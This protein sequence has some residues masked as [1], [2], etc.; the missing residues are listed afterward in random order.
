MTNVERRLIDLAYKYK[1]THLSSCLSTLPILQDIY[2]AK[3]PE[4]TVVL[5]NSHAALALYVTLEEHKLADADKL[6][7]EMGTHARRDLD[8]GIEVTGGSLGQA[9]TVAVGMALA[10]RSKTVYLVTSDG[11]CAEGSVWEALKIAGDNRLDNLRVAVIANGYSALDR[12]D[13]DYLEQRLQAFFPVTVFRTN[14]YEWPD[15]LQGVNGHYVMLDEA[16]YRE[17]TNNE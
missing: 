7:Q 14:L 16:K 6:A 4:D 17:V 2:N 10:D 8:S 11:A 5:G 12:V 15:W 1:L 13:L 3:K 9:E